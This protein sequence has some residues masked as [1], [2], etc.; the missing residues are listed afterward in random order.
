MKLVSQ[1][2]LVL[3]GLHGV[4]A[5][6]SNDYATTGSSCPGV[7][8]VV[9]RGTGQPPGYDLL[10]PMV[11]ELLAK[12]P[13][14]TAESVDYPACGGS[15]ACGGISYGDSARQGTAAVAKTVNA[16]HAACPKTQLVLMGYSQGMHIMDNALCGGPDPNARITDKTAPV[17]PSAAAMIKAVVGMGSPRYQHGLPYSYG[18]CSGHGFDARP[19]GFT[20]AYSS[21]MKSHCDNQD[22]YCCQGK[23]EAVHASYVIT[24]GKSALAWIESKL[25][26]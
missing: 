18:T 2:G 5:E 22:P 19:V 20:C 4:R 13:G 16:F 14:S 23:I 26:A 7:H 8:I 1:L 3:L 9:A 12:Y 21:K 6:D 10:L 24:Y 17:D 25:A 15:P 11:N